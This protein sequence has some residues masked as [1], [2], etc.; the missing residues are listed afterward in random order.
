MVGAAGFLLG[1]GE[2]EAEV[3]KAHAHKNTETDYR[4]MNRFL[5]LEGLFN[6]K[7][8]GLAA[9]SGR[10]KEPDLVVFFLGLLSK[11]F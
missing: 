8:A 5:D 3:S 11:D 1:A 6:T 2:L 10:V 9:I 4:K 7:P